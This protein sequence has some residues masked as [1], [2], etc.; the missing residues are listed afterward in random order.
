[1]GSTLSTEAGD[2][3]FYDALDGVPGA[4][5]V[6]GCGVAPHAARPLER[7]VPLLLSH[8]GARDGPLRALRLVNAAAC[9]AVDHSTLRLT[10]QGGRSLRGLVAAAPRFRA[11][12]ELVLVASGA[13]C[14]RALADAAPA[15]GA[16]L[17]R[18]ASITI[19]PHACAG[20]FDDA[21]PAATA[22]ASKLCALPGLRRLAVR[23]ANLPPAA[24]DVLISG[25]ACLPALESFGLASPAGWDG[26]DA[27]RA[28][29]K[30]PATWARLQ[31][32]E[33]RVGGAGR[34]RDWEGV[35]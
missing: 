13:A 28:A 35:P 21:A 12:R 7:L 23:L 32:G 31:V 19:T 1:M 27:L 16:T 26:S 9:A 33:G 5:G 10:V 14:L 15:L 2:E 24:C 11:L 3:V 8:L 30:R 25:A 29:L 6:A 4:E 20:P 34:A 17:P 22:P 18:L